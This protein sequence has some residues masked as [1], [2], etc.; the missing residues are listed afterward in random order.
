MARRR[1]APSHGSA[2]I[3]RRYP[4]V[5]LLHEEKAG[6]YVARNRGVAAARGEVLVFTDPDCIPDSDWLNRIAVAME[7]E[8]TDVLIGGYVVPEH[9]QAVRLLLLYENTK[10]A[11]VFG[12]D[13][14]ELYYAHTNNMAVRRTTFERF[15]P[16]VERRRGADT[17]FVRRVVGT[18]PC[19]VVRYDPA[20][21]VEH[22]EVAD[23]WTYFRKMATYGESRES[24]RH[25]SWTRPLT[26]GER[27][28]VLRRTL[29]EHTLSPVEGLRLVLLLSIGLVAWRMGRARARW[30]RFRNASAESAPSSPHTAPALDRST[31][32]P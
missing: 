24:Y 14:P 4:G 18:L 1:L 27:V 23:V 6:A 9:S 8:E 16:F 20:V 22:L 7:S 12:T 29:R 3:V 30:R 31:P 2:E 21:R 28:T 10:D 11:F 26:L 25:L 15:G 5:Q 17:I 32:L 19:R 13:I